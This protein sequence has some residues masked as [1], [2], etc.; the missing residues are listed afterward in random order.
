MTDVIRRHT[1]VYGFPGGFAACVYDPVSCLS[2][3]RVLMVPRRHY[4][5][6]LNGGFFAP[7]GTLSG[8]SGGS[9][10]TR[11]APAPGTWPR[12]EELAATADGPTSLATDAPASCTQGAVCLAAGVLVLP[13]KVKGPPTLPHKCR[14]TVPWTWSQ[15]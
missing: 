2:L 5:Q 15:Q 14:D 10:A 8:A 1:P 4:G 7:G 11:R 9:V 6:Q 13:R 12:A 3:P